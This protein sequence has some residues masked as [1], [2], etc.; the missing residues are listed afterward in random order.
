MQWP[1]DDVRLAFAGGAEI[2]TLVLSGLKH[3]YEQTTLSPIAN[4]IGLLWGMLALND[5]TLTPLAD[6]LRITQTVVTTG[7]LNLGSGAYRLSE[8]ANPALARKY[9]NYEP[10]VY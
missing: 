2:D 10:W 5:P 3:D 4:F 9:R 6:G 1:N 8:L 7:I